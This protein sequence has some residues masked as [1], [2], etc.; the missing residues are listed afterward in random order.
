MKKP[1]LNLAQ[2]GS[3][4]LVVEI[5]S[6]PKCDGRLRDLRPFGVIALSVCD[7]CKKFF[8]LQVTDVTSELSLKFKRDNLKSHA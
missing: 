2:W 5:N 6:C 4:S 7:K 8:G 3:L 1:K